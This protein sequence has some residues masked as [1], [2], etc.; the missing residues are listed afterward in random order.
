MVGLNEK[1]TS[2]GAGIAEQKQTF[3]DITLGPDCIHFEQDSARV[4]LESA[5][6]RSQYVKHNLSAF[7]RGNTK[8]RFEIYG[9]GIDKHVLTPNEAREFE[10]WEPLEGGDEFPAVPGAQMSTGEAVPAPAKAE[11]VQVQPEARAE[12]LAKAIAADLLRAEA[13]DMLK[14]AKATATNSKAWA[15]AIGAYYGRRRDVV[16][17]SLSITP[18]QARAYCDSQAKAASEAG[19]AGIETWAQTHAGKVIAIAVGG[20]TSDTLGATK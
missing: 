19:A 14:I 2:W 1:Q 7:L 15:D 6:T 12:A 5:G 13:Q 18:E 9:I 10:D 16:A 4:F 8:Q 11:D 17:M 3:V 20:N